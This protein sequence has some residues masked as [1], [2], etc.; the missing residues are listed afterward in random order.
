MQKPLAAGQGKTV[1]GVVLL[2]AVGQSVPGGLPRPLEADG[3]GQA[4]PDHG[5]RRW[6]CRVDAGLESEGRH[7]VLLTVDAQREVVQGA[8]NDSVGAIV[9]RQYVAVS[10]HEHPRCAGVFGGQLRRRCCV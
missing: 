5:L 3:G 7:L 6:R 9:Q 1:P 2:V 8:A 4:A 10:H